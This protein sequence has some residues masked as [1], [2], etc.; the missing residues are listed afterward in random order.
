MAV[1]QAD[2][3]VGVWA[4]PFIPRLLRS[5]ILTATRQG[6]LPTSCALLPYIRLARLPTPATSL[7]CS[8]AKLLTETIVIEQ[9]ADKVQFKN[10]R[11]AL[12]TINV[13]VMHEE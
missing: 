12:K 11:Q 7:P 5:H 4:T 10:G 6:R 8:N 13:K 1:T 9:E 3:S 2:H